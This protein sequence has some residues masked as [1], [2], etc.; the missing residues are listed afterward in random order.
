MDHSLKER[1]MAVNYESPS[2]R[3]QPPVVI[4][5]NKPSPTLAGALANAKKQVSAAGKQ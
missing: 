3:L 1:A 5:E 2:S 4:N